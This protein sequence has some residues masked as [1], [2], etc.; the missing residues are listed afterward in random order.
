VQPG[1]VIGER[2]VVEALA[3]EGGMGAVYRARD[4]HTDAFAAIKVLRMSDAQSLERF[5]REARILA[6]LRHP[7][8]VQYLVHGRT[9]RGELYLAMEW[10]VGEDLGARLAARELSLSE[11]IRLITQIAAALAVA[12]ARR[13]VH[14]DLKPSNL[15][16][17]E[18]RIERVKVLDF[19]VARL[20]P[21]ETITETGMIV[22]TPRFM[23]PE[24]ASGVKNVDARADVFA[25]GCVLFRCLTGAF[26]FA[27]ESPAE[28]LGRV[29]HDEARRVRELRPELPSE[30]DELV[31]RM[32]AKA[33]ADRPADAAAV[34][35]E[36]LTLDLTPA[37]APHPARV[38]L[39]EQELRVQCA[40]VMDLARPDETV[41]A[42]IAAH[43][44]QLGAAGDLT[45]VTLP[46]QRVT[47]DQAR[48]A[49]RCALAV[50]QHVAAS[51]ALVMGRLEAGTGANEVVAR[52]RRLLRS[53]DGPIR[54]DEATAGLLDARFT[55]VGDPDGLALHGAQTGDEETRTLLGKPTP[56][57]GREQELAQLEAVFAACVANREARAV[58][59][60]GAPGLGKSRLRQELTQRVQQRSPTVA[61]WTGRGDPMR[62]GAPFGLLGEAIR[63]AATIDGGEPLAVRRQRLYER[64]ARHVPAERAAHVAEFLG[65]IAGVPF[66][67]E[68]SVRLRSAR[69]DPLLLADQMRAAWEEWLA[70]ECEAQ[71]VLLVLE[72]LQWGDVPTV[73]FLDSALDALAE[74]PLMVL[75][76]A[77]P[78]VHDLFPRIWAERPLQSLHLGELGRKAGERL[79]RQI[80]GSAAAD[81]T[82]ARIVERAGGNVFYLEE[83]IRQVATGDR[84]LLPDTVLAMVEVRLAGLPAEAR[85]ALRA[86]SVFGDVFWAGGVKKLVG[87]TRA[88]AEVDQQLAELVAREVVRRRDRSHFEGETEHAFRHSLM[89]EA[90]YAMLTDRDRAL[91]HRLAGAWLE[92][93]GERDALVL[94]EH[95]ERGQ[96]RPRAVT[97]YRRAAEQ[98]LGGHD[99]AASIQRAE[100]G[101]ACG[102]AG[103]ELGLLRLVEAESHGW[104]GENEAAARHGIAAMRALPPGG[105][106]W[107]SAAGETAT[108]L[109]KLGRIAEMR[110][111]T[112]ELRAAG[113]CRTVSAAYAVAL[114]RA[115]SQYFLRKETELGAALC[116]ELHA[117][118]PPWADD[119]GVVAWIE[120]A[121]GYQAFMDSDTESAVDHHLGAA[122]SY[123]QAGDLRNACL[124][125]IEAA[126]ALIGAG[127][128]EEAE[129]LV[130]AALPVAERMRLHAATM[131]ALAIQTLALVFQGKSDPAYATATTAA[132]RF[133]SLME[134]SLAW[135]YAR[136]GLALALRMRGDLTGAEARLREAFALG[137]PKVLSVRICLARVCLERGD[138]AAALGIV[139][140]V[141]LEMPEL[142][143]WRPLAE[144]VLGEASGAVGDEDEARAAIA[145][146]RESMLAGA[147][148]LKNPAYARSYLEHMPDNRRV[149]E[150]ARAWLG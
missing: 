101:V 32:L 12:H 36:C 80:L 47:T 35:A 99:M 57:V 82:V 122:R 8:F 68:D 60:T 40:L 113:A 38:E 140:P 86:A 134:S 7:G 111:V 6:E 77:R 3:A 84:Q 24:Q 45:V 132:E 50:R 18:D 103:E 72:D 66:P 61:V 119:P 70:A 17:V 76:L 56:F 67:T 144:L 58:L 124:A 29:I 150:L 83:L 148:H 95:Y 106:A 43:G 141:L 79:V 98:A 107:F 147:A 52:A 46:S 78:E 109:G 1:D 126:D 14:R 55:V 22:G 90:A 42:L 96:D 138:P 142:H 2:F 75:G 48:M 136:L 53:P 130:A 30:L 137:Q 92:G 94:A 74:R 37:A 10:L 118:E 93:A 20:L 44:G 23:A 41:R 112:D 11:S 88:A 26:P 87:E 51:M 139:R 73:K 85:R 133:P 131:L 63:R 31:A 15:F 21:L 125:Q 145:R 62:A 105:E 27:G 89:R 54:L 34:L 100:K 81:D 123:E 128:A 110:A 149:A 64:V 39:T 108:A 135:T 9:E 65:E 28:L 102:A 114:A 117:P 129:R 146:A 91:G 25:L 127:I 5:A 104:L 49:A 13:I 4:R 143:Y 121:F 71:P 115:A 19:G 59:V 116:A 33:P 16:L 97:C 120:T 69:R